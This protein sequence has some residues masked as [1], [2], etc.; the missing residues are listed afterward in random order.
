LPGVL[1]SVRLA[2]PLLWNIANITES[3]AVWDVKPLLVPFRQGSVLKAVEVMILHSIAKI[4]VYSTSNL[5]AS[6]CPLLPQAEQITKENEMRHYP[7]KSF[8]KM[9]ESGNQENQV[10]VQIANPNLIVEKQALNKRMNRNP[11][12]PKPLL[13][14][15]SKMTISLAL[16]SGKLYPKGALQPP[17]SWLCKSPISKSSLMESLVDL[18]FF[19]SFA[20][21]SD[22]F[23]E[24]LLAISLWRMRTRSN[25]LLGGKEDEGERLVHATTG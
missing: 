6:N 7:H 9:D 19:Y 13:K 4:E 15:S 1:W 22:L 8:T 21:V 14:K 23:L 24:S 3:R 10:C 20:I 5:G 25:W 12:T 2:H 18:D 16:G 17:S 11:E